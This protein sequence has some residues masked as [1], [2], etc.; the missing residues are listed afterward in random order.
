MRADRRQEGRAV[1]GVGADERDEV[2]A[3]V[4]AAGEAPVVERR[5]A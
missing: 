5:S 4:V 3:D 1:A 2:A